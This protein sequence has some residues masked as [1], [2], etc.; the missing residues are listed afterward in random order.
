MLALPNALQPSSSAGNPDFAITIKDPSA[1]SNPS[2]GVVP[3]VGEFK[4]SQGNH[5]QAATQMACYAWAGLSSLLVAGMDVREAVVM[6]FTIAGVPPRV[7]FY[8][9]HAVPHTR[10]VRKDWYSRVG[11]LP[12]TP[13]PKEPCLKYIVQSIGRALNLLDPSNNEEAVGHFVQCYRHA[14]SVCPESD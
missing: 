2:M 13:R 9:V 5:A 11:A 14:L 6:G 7:I 8:G 12:Y 3:V 4:G 10:F 1:F